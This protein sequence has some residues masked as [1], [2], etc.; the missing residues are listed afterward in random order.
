ML[1]RILAG[2]RRKPWSAYRYPQ[3]GLKENGW[4]QWAD[5]LSDLLW[6]GYSQD[7]TSI[8]ITVIAQNIRIQDHGSYTG[9]RRVGVLS[10][11]T[12]VLSIV[13]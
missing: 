6:V 3:N 10:T 12:Q 8:A 4:L 11:A 7:E 1:L 2:T 13:P 5:N 9:D